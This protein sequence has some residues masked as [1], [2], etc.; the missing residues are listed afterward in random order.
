MAPTFALC[1]R[2]SSAGSAVSCKP[3]SARPGWILSRAQPTEGARCVFLEI[4]HVHKV[5]CICLSMLCLVEFIVSTFSLS[6]TPSC[7]LSHC[8]SLRLTLLS[9]PLPLDVCLSLTVSL[10]R[11]YPVSLIPPSPL[12]PLAASHFFSLPASA[13]RSCDQY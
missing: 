11:C 9:L 6:H 12:P 13:L 1:C 4:V 10:P 2:L 8:I 5:I 3:L 7:L